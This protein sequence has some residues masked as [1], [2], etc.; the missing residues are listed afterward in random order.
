[1]VM[2][3]LTILMLFQQFEELKF[4]FFFLGSMPPDPVKPFRPDL[5]G[6]VPILLDNPESLL[7]FSRDMSAPTLKISS[8]KPTSRE[9]YIFK[10]SKYLSQ[11]GQT[12]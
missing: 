4:L 9:V 12:T 3:G 11:D 10:L 7:S 8:Y 5:G 2:V 6:I 1:M